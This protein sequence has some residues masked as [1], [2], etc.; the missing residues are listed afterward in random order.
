MSGRAG[1]RRAG[2]DETRKRDEVMAYRLR[3]D[4]SIA[5]GLRRV[6]RKELESA[7]EELKN[8]RGTAAGKTI[9]EVRK[10][11]KKV[12]AIVALIESD[13]GRGLGKSR[14]RLRRVSRALS[15]LRDADA[16]LELV[17]TLQ[18]GRRKAFDE[19]TVARIRK[20]LTAEQ[21]AVAA[22][23]SKDRVRQRI[24]RDIT[25]LATAAKRWRPRHK[26]V[27]ALEPGLR[28]VFRRGQK[29]R[30]RAIEQGRAADFHEWRKGLKALWYQLRLV[31]PFAP[32]L[33]KQIQ[34]LHQ[35]TSWLGD[36]HN[37]D[38]FC[39]QVVA[40][41]AQR[42][43]QEVQRVVSRFQDDLRRKAVGRTQAFFEPKPAVFVRNVTR[44]LKAANRS[45]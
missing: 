33:G 39:R 30:T 16:V 7:H 43:A 41:G 35:A 28:R 25:K 21:R 14:K 19:H 5:D 6:A 2:V 38:V 12:R 8:D 36:D 37:A 18:R 17:D 15:P 45:K 3:A 11:I 34:L 13:R 1:A 44:A 22:A 31:E 20:L 40:K 27:R 10:R 42:D 24:D 4:E 29:A 26:R 32:A 23:A 9:H